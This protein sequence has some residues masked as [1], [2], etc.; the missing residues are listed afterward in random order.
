MKRNLK[1]YAVY[2]NIKKVDIVFFLFQEKE[3]KTFQ[4]DGQRNIY[5][6]RVASQIYARVKKYFISSKKLDDL[7]KFNKITKK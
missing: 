7:E 6:L 1:F 4:T 2:T 3:P 5:Y